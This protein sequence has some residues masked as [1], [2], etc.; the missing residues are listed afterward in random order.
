MRGDPNM[1]SGATHLTCVDFD[2]A[3]AAA[4][5]IVET[6][7]ARRYSVT[8]EAELQAEIVEVLQELA[9]G[10]PLFVREAW[11][12]PRDRADFLLGAIAVEVK[13]A[14]GLAPVTRQLHRYAAHPFVDALVLVTTRAAHRA[15]PSTLQGKPCRVAY[16]PPL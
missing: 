1:P 3:A 2:R 9:T 15:V 12:S 11:L 16:L 5:R 7:T 6:V 14:G 8:D 4:E 13:V 10:M